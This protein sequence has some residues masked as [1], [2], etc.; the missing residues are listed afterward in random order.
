MA[1]KSLRNQLQ[2]SSNQDEVLWSFIYTSPM[3][4]W[5]WWETTRGTLEP[6]GSWPLRFRSW[7][8]VLILCFLY[9]QWVGNSDGAQMGQLAPLQDAWGLSWETHRLE[10]RIFWR[11]I[12]SHVQWLI[13]V[14][15]LWPWFL[16]TLS[17]PNGLST[18]AW[19]DFLT[20]G[21]LGSKHKNLERYCVL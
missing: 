2:S 10:T 11:L 3:P 15:G 4:V 5:V 8:S 21:C 17:S 12:H 6:W 13:L 18:W 7:V 1:S 9:I 16:S 14:V 20:A 19:L